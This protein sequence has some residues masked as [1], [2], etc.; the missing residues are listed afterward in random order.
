MAIWTRVLLIFLGI[1]VAFAVSG[2]TLIFEDNF[3]FLDF[4]KWK[5]E[6]TES[7]G[8]NWESVSYVEELVTNQDGYQIRVLYKQPFKHI[9]SQFHPLHQAHLVDR[10]PRSSG[11][12]F[13]GLVGW[14]TW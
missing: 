11:Q 6:I 3:D 13:A 5:H 8:G 2:E 9:C 14:R 12:W 10:S 4:S 7:G 1:G